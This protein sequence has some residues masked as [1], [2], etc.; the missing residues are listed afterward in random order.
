[1]QQLNIKMKK[2]LQFTAVLFFGTA[3]AQQQIGNGNL[4]TWE[5]LGAPTEE[6]TNWNSF[7]TAGGSFSSFGSVQL[8]QS[9]TV[10]AGATGSYSARIWSV[11]VF[12]VIA[13]GN[14]TLGKINMGS[15]TASSSSNYN[16]SIISDANFSESL[17]DMPDSIVFWVKYTATNASDSARASVILHDSYE[18]R[19][20]IDVNSESHTVA[21]AMLN[22]RETGGVWVRK[23]IPFDYAGPASANTF[24]L[25]TFTTNKTPGGGTANDEVLID[26]VELI[27]NPA[28]LFELSDSKVFTSIENNVLSISAMKNIEGTLVVYNTA[29]QIV[30]NEKI[31]SSIEFNELPGIYYLELD[32]QF[33]KVHKKLVNY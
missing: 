4:E 31:S 12:G 27:Y 33:G 18:H 2:L 23:S 17:T 21:T 13:N 24:I 25:A 16:S 26:D 3:F 11:S 20:P 6:P 9:T 22:Y 5:N 15:T 1:M 7:K 30:K 28:N 8:E 29:G 19:D 32:T 14:M 10:R